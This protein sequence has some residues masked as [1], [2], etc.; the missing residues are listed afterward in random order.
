[1]FD[2]GYHL[3]SRVLSLQI[4]QTQ[5]I[6]KM[7]VATKLMQEYMAIHMGDLGKEVLLEIWILERVKREKIKKIR[8]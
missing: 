7:E 5:L 2:T 3:Q 8:D 1:M 4:H 6:D